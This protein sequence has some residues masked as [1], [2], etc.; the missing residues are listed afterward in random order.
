[1]TAGRTSTTTRRIAG[2][3]PV[4]YGLQWKSGNKIMRTINVSS[5]VNKLTLRYKQRFSSNEWKDMIYP[6]WLDWTWCNYGN[7]RAWFFCPVKGCGRH[8]AILY[9]GAIF[10][11]R[12]CHKLAYPCQR[13][14]SPD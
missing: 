6:V 9:D 14:T 11:C 13:E 5:E 2:A 4:F 12:H 7:Y 3:G 10:V 1:M 8:V